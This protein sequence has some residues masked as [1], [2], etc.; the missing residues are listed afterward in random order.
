MNLLITGGCGYIGSLLIRKLPFAF[1]DKIDITVFDNLSSGR[2]YMLA[3]LP[4]K[5]KYR[6]FRGDVLKKQDLLKAMENKDIVI[7][8]AAI[9]GV[10]DSFNMP[11]LFMKVN[12]E[13]TKNVVETC[14]EQGIGR[15][16]YASTCNVYGG[17]REN[18]VL[19]EKSPITP[20]NPYADSKYKGELECRKY[21][22]D[23]KLPVTCLRFAT[24]YGWSPGI[25]FNLAIN[26]FTF[27][28]VIGEKIKI[29]DTGEDWR[30][31]IHVQDTVRAITAAIKAPEDV[32]IGE[33]FNVGSNEENYKVNQVAQLVK[34]NV[35]NDV[36]IVHIEKEGLHFSYKVE[37]SKIK[38]KL[39]F[40]TRFSVVDGIKE[41][42][43]KFKQLFN[44]SKMLVPNLTSESRHYEKEQN[45]HITS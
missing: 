41:L 6:F 2:E 11:D 44:N 30:P 42:A 45:Q 32:A 39:G 7:H 19:N 5:A 23:Y 29:F 4:S 13:G 33:V 36:D 10:C 37:F 21:H 1:T 26:L 15:L 9:T 43:E 12:Y 40:H 18:K 22:K 28:A 3:N 25:R 8:L 24:N 27:K 17:K 16:I 35:E 34:E 14:L 31:Y 20:P 38:Q